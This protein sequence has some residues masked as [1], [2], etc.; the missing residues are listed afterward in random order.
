MNDKEKI[1]KALKSINK[2]L[3]ENLVIGVGY[4]ELQ[5]IKKI[6]EED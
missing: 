3:H 1:E 6:L 5:K 4:F 2:T